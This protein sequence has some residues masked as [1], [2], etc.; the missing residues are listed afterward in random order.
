MAID[1]YDTATALLKALEASVPF[2]V[3]PGK[4]LLKLMKN[5]GTPLSAERGYWVEKV[6]YSGDE[7]GILCM[8]KPAAT[9]KELV[10]SSLT[11][12]I[13]D[14]AHPLAASVKA[15]QRQRSHRLMLQDQRGFAALAS[16]SDSPLKRKKRGGGFGVG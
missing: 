6:I 9:D 2:K 7:G 11:H 15:Y 1:D 8:L 16:S 3:R 4:Q 12:L 5:K 14:P 10:G 13:I